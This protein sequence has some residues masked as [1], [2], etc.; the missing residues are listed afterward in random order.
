M[1]S[2][3]RSPNISREMLTG[4]PE[5]RFDLDFPGTGERLRLLLAFCKLFFREKAHPLIR[6]NDARVYW[7]AIEAFM[8]NVGSIG[9]PTSAG[10]RSARGVSGPDLRRRDRVFFTGTALLIL[11]IVFAGFARTYYLAGV[12]HA[13]LPNL[14]IHIHGAFFSC[15]VLLLAAQT[16]LVAA[17]RVDLHRRLGL[18]GFALAAAMVVLGL[19]AATDMMA[20]HMAPGAP[21]AEVR[22]F[23]AIPLADMVGFATLIWFG[24]RERRRPAAH[25]RL[26]L[27]ATIALLDAAFVRWPV[28]APWWYLHAAEICCYVLLLILMSYDLWSLGRI[29]RVTLWASALLVVLQ[30]GRAPLGNTALWQGFASWVQRLALSFR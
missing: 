22:A 6:P 20:R 9:L 3:Q 8:G 27:I 25:K 18:L 15:W 23:Y 30:Q 10:E 21:G 13:P 28:P 5:R 16:S 1:R 14:L 19:L 17:G 12:F 2:D 26:M 4:Q 24:Y 29:Q 7:P 11:G